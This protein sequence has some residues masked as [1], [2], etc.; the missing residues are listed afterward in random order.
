MFNLYF[1]KITHK[2]RDLFNVLSKCNAFAKKNRN[3]GKNLHN[4]SEFD[5]NEPKIGILCPGNTNSNPEENERDPGIDFCTIGS[6][7][8]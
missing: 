1:A 2:H 8:L 3:F 5:K 7:V 4:L 6:C